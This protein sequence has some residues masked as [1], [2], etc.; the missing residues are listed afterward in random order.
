[1]SYLNRKFIEVTIFSVYEHED[2]HEDGNNQNELITET[3]HV[4]TYFPRY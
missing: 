3:H 4:S 1:M 2:E